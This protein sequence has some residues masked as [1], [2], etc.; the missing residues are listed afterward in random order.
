MMIRLLLTTLCLLFASCTTVA[1]QESNEESLGAYFRHKT[2]L[3]PDD[4][5]L[6]RGGEDAAASSDT[7]LVVADG[8]G[9]WIK[10]NVNP[11]LYSGLLTKTVVELFEKSD[12]KSQTSLVDLVHE[13]NWIAAKAHLGSA[14]CT[15]LKISSPSTISTLNVGDS[16]YALFRLVQENPNSGEKPTIQLLY[17][18]IPGQKSFNFPHQL[19]GKYGDAVKDVGVEATHEFE[20]GDIIVVFSDGVSDNIAAIEFLPCI[21]NYLN[22]DAV[23]DNS[24]MDELLLS[25][26]LV[27]DCIARNAYVLGKD[28]TFDSPFAQGAREAG[29]G[30]YSGG[31]H[32]DITVT[33]AQV[34]VGT[35]LALEKNTDPHYSE[36]IYLYTGPIPPV[37]ELPTKEQL[38]QS[39]HVEL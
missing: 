6:H 13:A 7:I 10:Q 17:E 25:Y 35:K 12:N 27:A 30:D 4:S 19:G 37:S 16:G 14:T 23:G 28:E 33:V 9:G 2:V 3:I 15:T 32:D 8:V 20:N 24:K 11:G 39:Q 21:D 29:W 26:S 31:K 1:G 5:K 18:T 22:E 34:F 36:S 38:R